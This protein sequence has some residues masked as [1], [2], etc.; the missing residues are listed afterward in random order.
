M[1]GGKWSEEKFWV[2]KV[3]GGKL[4]GKN[5][6][7][8]TDLPEAGDLPPPTGAAEPWA[9]ML[10]DDCLCARRVDNVNYFES[11]CDRSSNGV[12]HRDE[13]S[14]QPQF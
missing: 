7:R 10:R 11:T 1:L 4:V 6:W 8:K 3:L 2:E 5:A 12:M 13:S 14:S 9:E